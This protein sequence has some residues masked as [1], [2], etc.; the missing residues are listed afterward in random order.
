MDGNT[1]STKI[2]H[3]STRDDITVLKPQVSTH[4]K[5][6]VYGTENLEFALLFGSK[7]RHGDFDGIYGID[8]NG[9]A[10]FEEAFE[11]SLKER[12]D[13]QSCYIYELDPTDFQQGKTSFHGEVVSEKPVKVLSCTKVENVYDRLQ[14]ASK[15]GK[16][17]LTEFKK[18]DPEYTAKIDEHV[19]ERMD[20]FHITNKY[21]KGYKFCKE[22][23]PHLIERQKSKAYAQAEAGM[24]LTRQRTRF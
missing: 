16:I 6:Y 20:R 2:Y 14:E 22:K 7:N 13:G 1:G 19:T 10:F 17:K 3:V 11:N 18:D 15:E 12:F 8:E 23:F 21:A 9:T 4:G 24:E 5:P